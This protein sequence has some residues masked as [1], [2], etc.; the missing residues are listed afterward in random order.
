MRPHKGTSFLKRL[1]YASKGLR[2]ALRREAS[3]RTQ[4][5]FALGL[6]AFCIYIRPS[7]VWCALFT[8]AAVVV[9]GL[10]LVNTAVESLLDKLHPEEHKEIGFIKDCLAAAVLIA[11]IGSLIVFVFFLI[12]K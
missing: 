1:I 2:E 8:L 3:F 11:S 6:L 4:S 12:S 10:E 9:L 7:M 5:V